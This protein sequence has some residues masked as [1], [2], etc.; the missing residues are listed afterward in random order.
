[1]TLR[2]DDMRRMGPRFQGENFQKNLLLVEK[3][4]EMATEREC[5]ASQLA[6]AWVV[7]Q[8]ENIFPIPGTRRIKYLEE[9]AAA[10]QVKLTCSRY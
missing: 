6:L 3:I 10:L 1:M 5:T 7:A 2:R 9:N 8:D 4:E